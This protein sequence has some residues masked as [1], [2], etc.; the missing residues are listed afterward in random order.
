VA[1][2]L[3]IPSFVI[4]CRKKGFYGFTSQL[5][6]FS[7]IRRRHHCRWR[8]VKFSLCPALRAIEQEGYLSCHTCC[9]PTGLINMHSD[10]LVIYC[11][12]S[13]SRMK[14]LR[15]QNISFMSRH[16]HCRWRTTKFRPMF[17]AQS[18][19]AERDLY[20]A[21]PAMTPYPYFSC[22]IQRTATFSRLLRHTRGCGGS[23]LAQILSGFIINMHNDSVVIYCFTSC[24][25]MKWLQYQYISLT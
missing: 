25:R 21:T 4:I 18:L 19:W 1:Q 13:R 8:A 9:D 3:Q 17:G 16:H 20:R 23:F 2:C 12:T 22:L 24:S 10:W 11:F 5:K 6:T 7:L 14:W 15:H